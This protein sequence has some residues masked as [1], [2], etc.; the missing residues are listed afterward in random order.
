MSNPVPPEPSFFRRYRWAIA[1]LL[2]T[3]LVVIFLAPLASS[4]P[5][6]LDRVSE[7][8]GFADQGKDSPYS[9]LPDY[10]VPGID[11]ERATVIISGLIGV[12]IVFVLTM[13]FGAYVRQQSRRST[14]T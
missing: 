10:S 2:I 5:D 8:K 1:G 11:D 13:A 3:V 14:N 7:D 4:D 9:F 12:A 6:G